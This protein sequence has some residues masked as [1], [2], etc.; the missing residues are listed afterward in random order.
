MTTVF[1]KNQKLVILKP[2]FIDDFLSTIFVYAYKKPK[3]EALGM[4]HW[5]L[6]ALIE[7]GNA[8]T[9][10]LVLQV[11]DTVGLRNQSISSW[12]VS[13]PDKLKVNQKLTVAVFVLNEVNGYK[14]VSYAT[15]KSITTG[16]ILNI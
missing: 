12:N 2:S 16:N 9:D 4:P 8:S 6:K 1:V 5:K 10:N 3:N 7:E 15:S 13:V 14:N 11:N